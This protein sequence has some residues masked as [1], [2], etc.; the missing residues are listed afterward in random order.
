MATG[1]I[2]TACANE[3]ASDAIPI[4]RGDGTSPSRWMAK[5][6]SAL[7]E[8]RCVGRTRLTIEALIG[9]V[10]KNIKSCAITK[11]TKYKVVEAAVSANHANGAAI[12]V[13]IADIQRYARCEYLAQ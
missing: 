9:P 8:A 13:A 7:A 1:T 10:D 5:T 4:K 12:K 6:P 11:Q 3:V 2:L